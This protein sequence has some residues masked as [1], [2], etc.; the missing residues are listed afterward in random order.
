MTQSEIKPMTLY[1]ANV[2]GVPKNTGYPYEMKITCAEDMA[3]AA[4]FDNVSADYKL[5]LELSLLI[6]STVSCSRRLLIFAS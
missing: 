1:I 3:K 2:R 6:S 4:A 5:L